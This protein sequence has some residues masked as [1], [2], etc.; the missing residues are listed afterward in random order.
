MGIF[1]IT[2][3]LII[4]EPNPFTMPFQNWNFPRCQRYPNYPCSNNFRVWKVLT[5]TYVKILQYTS[6]L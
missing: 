4:S 5:K 6:L 3:I 2:L 1:H